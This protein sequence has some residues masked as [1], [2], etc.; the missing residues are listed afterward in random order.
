MRD[1]TRVNTV[2]MEEDC[3]LDGKKVK[4]TKKFKTGNNIRIKGEDVKKNKEF[5]YL[6]E[7]SGQWILHNYLP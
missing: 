5:F 7:K 4:I 6:E 2:C 1:I 3:Y